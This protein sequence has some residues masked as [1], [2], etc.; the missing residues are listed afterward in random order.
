AL[1]GGLSAPLTVLHPAL[2]AGMF[3][4]GAEVYLR[5]PKVADFEALKDDVLSFAGW[6]RNRVARALL[7][8]VLTNFA[9]MIGVYTAGFEMFRRL[10][11]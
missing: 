9:T 10:S 1:A 8:F 4:A 6:R 5:R 3:S 2:A 7:V 11:E